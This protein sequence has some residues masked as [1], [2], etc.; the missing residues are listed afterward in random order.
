ML[1]HILVNGP[2]YTP[3]NPRFLTGFDKIFLPLLQN[4]LRHARRVLAQTGFA[5]HQRAVTD[6]TARKMNQSKNVVS[7]RPFGPVRL[8]I[9]DIR[10]ASRPFWGVVVVCV[11]AW[12]GNT[13]TIHS[14]TDSATVTD[15][16]TATATDSA[17]DDVSQTPDFR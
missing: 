3:S 7:E 17:T 10:G 4:S 9:G 11:G 5:I 15:S 14:V 8:V 13:S 1:A 6:V 2:G 12:I 16:V